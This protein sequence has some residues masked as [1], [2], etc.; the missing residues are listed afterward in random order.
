MYVS[1]LTA[2][3]LF[4]RCSKIPRPYSSTT[5]FDISFVFVASSS[6]WGVDT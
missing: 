1:R 2:V 3:S 6:I 5:R 4:A